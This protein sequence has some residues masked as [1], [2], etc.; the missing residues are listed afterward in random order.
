VALAL[1]MVL[2]FEAGAEDVYPGAADGAWRQYLSDPK[3]VEARMAA[4][5]P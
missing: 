3:A 1:A 5:L 4:R 2:A